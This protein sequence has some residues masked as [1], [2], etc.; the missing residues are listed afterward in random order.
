MP[1]LKFRV[2]NDLNNIFVVSNTGSNGITPL[3]F[4]FHLINFGLLS[5]DH[6]TI[7]ILIPT[8][9]YLSSEK[10]VMLSSSHQAFVLSN[11]QKSVKL[12]IYCAAYGA[13]RLF[14]LVYYIPEQSDWEDPMW[15]S[16]AVLSLLQGWPLHS[17]S[18]GSAICE[19]IIYTKLFQW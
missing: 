14:S 6:L 17:S 13:E 10:A 2:I 11:C 5:R 12:V 16:Q 15:Q 4:C 18:Q 3:W 19:R 7:S 1:N 8:L 9:Q